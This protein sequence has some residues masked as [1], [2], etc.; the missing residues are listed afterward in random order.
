VSAKAKNG[1]E[2]CRCSIIKGARRYERIAQEREEVRVSAKPEYLFLRDVHAF[3]REHVGVT[4]AQSTI[5][6][7]FSPSRGEGPAPAAFWGRRPVFLPADVLAWAKARLTPT[8]E[9][10]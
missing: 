4:L 2:C 10:T 8:R 9:P 6:K 5:E 1:G 7:M 3:L